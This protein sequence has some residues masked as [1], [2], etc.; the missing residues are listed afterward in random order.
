MLFYLWNS[1]GEKE[2]R[3]HFCSKYNFTPPH[4]HALYIRQVTSNQILGGP[5]RQ[6]IFDSLERHINHLLSRKRYSLPFFR[7]IPAAPVT[8]TL[9]GLFEPTQCPS[10]ALISPHALL[11]EIQSYNSDKCYTPGPQVPRHRQEKLTQCWIVQL[12]KMHLFL[13]LQKLEGGLEVPWPPAIDSRRFEKPEPRCFEN[14][15]NISPSIGIDSTLSR[16]L[17]L[18]GFA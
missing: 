5:D 1:N 14:F 2:K 17:S 11:S 13:L 12:L 16:L 3:A 7:T 15:Y 4:R 18:L 8:R 10:R 9:E 6:K